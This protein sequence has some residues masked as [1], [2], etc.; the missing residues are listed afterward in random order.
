MKKK[1]KIS[2]KTRER[3][4]EDDIII[5][6]INNK[7]SYIEKDSNCTKVLVDLNNKILIRENKELYLE[8]NFSNNNG[9]VYLK[10]LGSSININLKTI[11]YKCLNKKIEIMYK[12]DE[13]SYE[14]RIEM[15]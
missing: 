9:V 5:E 7:I 10:D 6:L 1:A 15:E 4:I 8:Y 3:T 13:N 2:L 14:Y 11:D 12:I